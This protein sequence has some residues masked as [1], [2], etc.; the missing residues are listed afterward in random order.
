MTLR[1][2][3]DIG[4][5]LASVPTDARPDIVHV[6]GE[7]PVANWYRPDVTGL[8]ARG[9]P[10]PGPRTWIRNA[11]TSGYVRLTKAVR[12]VLVPAS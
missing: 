3:T 6:V 12:N 7:I 5:T 9:L 4:G 10:K 1:H 8:A 2:A 11:E